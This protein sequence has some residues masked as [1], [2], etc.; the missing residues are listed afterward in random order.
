[1]STIIKVIIQESEEGGYVAHCPA[2]KGCMSQGETLEEVKENIKE[3]AAGWLESRVLLDLKLLIKKNQT[4]KVKKN[5]DRIENLRIS[6]KL[7][8][9]GV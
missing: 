8:L 6:P 9:A 3:A 1:M 2:L 4:T 7:A 5:G